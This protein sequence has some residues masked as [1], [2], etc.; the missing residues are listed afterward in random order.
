[1]YAGVPNTVWVE[2]ASE[3]TVAAP[4]PGI[5]GCTAATDGVMSTGSVPANAETM[6]DA[7]AVPW[8]SADGASAAVSSSRRAIPKSTTLTPP[9]SSTTT[10]S[11][12]ISRWSTPWWCAS[13][14]AAVTRAQIPRG[15]RVR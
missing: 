10:F 8:S 4:E 15:E 1:M 12:L 13:E 2:L 6:R 14:I 5:V 11:G 3:A 9:E 7:R